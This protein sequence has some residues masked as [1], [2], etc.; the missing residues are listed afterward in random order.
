MWNFNQIT[1]RR[2]PVWDRETS[3]VAGDQRPKGDDNDGRAGYENREYMMRVVV[4]GWKRLQ[5]TTP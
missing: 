3:V 1:E 4:F 2:R 5:K